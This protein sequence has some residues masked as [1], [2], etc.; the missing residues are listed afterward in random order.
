MTFTEIPLRRLLFT[1]VLCGLLLFACAYYNTFYNA[2]KQ[3]KKAE[4]ALAANPPVA[5]PSSSQR[6]LYEQA[7]KKASKVLTFHPN[8]K[9]VDDA[10]FLMGKSYFRMEE[11]GKAQRKFEEL[12]AN[13]PHSNFRWEAQYLLG[14]IHYYLD[15]YPN[16][17]DA[18]NLIIEAKQNNPWR[19]DAR[20]L[21]GEVALASGDYKSAMENFRTI[22][23]VYPRSGLKAEA[24]FK[25]GEC[26]FQLR[27]YSAALA[28]FQE[29]SHLDL[30]ADRHYQVYLRIGECQLRLKE[31]QQALETFDRLAGS[32]RYVDRLLETR[33]R[34][35]EV[36]HLQGDRARA[37]EEYK[38]IVEKNVKTEETAWAYYQL[39]LI[40]MEDFSDLSEAKGY[41]D[42]SK[43]AFATSNGARLS[44]LKR[45]QIDKLEEQL[46]KVAATDSLADPEAHFALAE[47]YLLDLNQPDSALAHYRKVL[48]L[49]PLSKSAPPSSYAAAWI[50]EHILGDTATSREMYQNLIDSYPFSTS[51]DAARERLGRPAIVD[52]SQ[53]DAAERLRRAEDLLLKGNDVDAALAAYRSLVADFPHSPFAP[54]A[55]CAIAWTLE[56]LQGD[57]DS[58]MVIFRRVAE[59]YPNS[60]CGALAQKKITPAP[61]QAPGDTTT[62]VSNGETSDQQE[63]SLPPERGEEEP[64]QEGDEMEPIRKRQGLSKE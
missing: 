16:A 58:A 53:E 30:R 24:I 50:V 22:P 54:K 10:L 46:K 51:A 7:I 55:E 45:N 39:G 64:D 28:A 9:Y 20:F 33:L 8:S 44:S 57:R 43:S 41:F 26:H 32:D 60:E 61:A 56:N 36:H 23:E 49:V 48:E 13:Y 34:I 6:D 47:I 5:G 25:V 3:F 59:K 31:Y 42:K 18:L 1:C 11:F 14:T 35:A 21:L 2:K 40:S 15:D 27:N 12:L 37:I 19:D 62:Q 17:R 29:A 38:N 63:E 4:E 52:T